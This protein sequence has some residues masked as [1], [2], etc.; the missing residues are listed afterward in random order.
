MKVSK[1]FHEL[2]KDNKE[3][4]NENFVKNRPLSIPNNS[5]SVILNISGV[6]CNIIINNN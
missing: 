4:E 3:G 6:Y 5:G 1:M 2:S